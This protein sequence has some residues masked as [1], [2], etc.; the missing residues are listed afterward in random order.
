MDDIDLVA[1]MRKAVG[2]AGELSR[3][4]DARKLY[5]RA[6]YVGLAD[7]GKAVLRHRDR[8]RRVEIEIAELAGVSPEY[9]LVDIPKT[10]EMLEMQAMEMDLWRRKNFKRKES[11]TSV[12][13]GREL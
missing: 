12:F 3:L 2:Y 13:T 1:S 6:L 9:V 11:K 10:P 4:L 5:K 8:I 7:V